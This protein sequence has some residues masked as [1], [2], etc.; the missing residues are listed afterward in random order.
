MSKPEFN[1]SCELCKAQLQYGM[2]AKDLKIGENG[3]FKLTLPGAVI[4]CYHS[5]C[6]ES[7]RE[8]G[9]G[10]GRGWRVGWRG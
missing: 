10:R 6:D 9:R 8:E 5:W 2:K 3:T 1:L 4:L 7:Q